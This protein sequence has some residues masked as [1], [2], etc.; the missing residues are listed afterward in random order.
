MGS[1]SKISNP[2]AVTPIVSQALSNDTLATLLD[3]SLDCIKLV[4]LDGSLQYMNRNGLCAMQIDDFSIVLGRAWE[5]LWPDGSRELIAD[6]MVRAAAGEAVRFDA[7]CPTAKGEP[8]WWDVSC[9]AV[10]DNKGES[11]GYLS[12]SRDVTAARTA[13]E[14]AEIASAEMRHRLKNSY[15]M[16]AGLLSSLARGLPEREAFAEEI[17]TRLSALA[18]AQTLFVARENAPCDLR[19]LLPALLQPFQHQDCPVLT[20]NITAMAVDQGDADALALVLGELAVNSSK[21]GALS[22]VGS[23]KVSALAKDSNLEVRW[24]EQSDRPVQAHDRE[25][26][27]GLRLM[28]RI[29]AARGG[30]VVVEWHDFG[31]EATIRL[32]VTPPGEERAG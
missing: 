9:S 13:R 26:G 10:R 1:L 6:A 5:S 31:L 15:A 21:H 16:V 32:S 11:I 12:V 14:V 17:R 30:A 28:Q 23:I 20:E 27:Q 4:G 2:G 25:G 24:L 3:Q 18:V 29:L 7:F 8:R 19:L 22:G